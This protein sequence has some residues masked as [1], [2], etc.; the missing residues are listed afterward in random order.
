MKSILSIAQCKGEWGNLEDGLVLMLLKMQVDTTRSS[1][2]QLGEE[3]T[4]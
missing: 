3:A 1:E 2:L 4:Q